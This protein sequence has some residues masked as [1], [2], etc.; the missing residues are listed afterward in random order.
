MN[1]NY[2]KFPRFIFYQQLSVSTYFAMTSQVHIKVEGSVKWLDV[3]R[4]VLIDCLAEHSGGRYSNLKNK[5]SAWKSVVADFNLK[6]GLSYDKPVLASQV[7]SL[8]KHWTIFDQ[9]ANNSG[10]GMDSKG[11]VTAAPEALNTYFRHTLRRPNFQ[12]FLFLFTASF[13][14]SFP[15]SED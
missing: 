5:K 10:F 12:A 3:N 6:T 14:Y 2:C 1:C 8:K 13:V 7:Q 9:F 11:M 4:K 15:V